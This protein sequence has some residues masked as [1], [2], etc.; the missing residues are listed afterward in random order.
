MMG[1]GGGGVEI[2][3]GGGGVL[4]GCQ[5]GEGAAGCL[6]DCLEAVGCQGGSR[7]IKR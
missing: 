2:L 5:N 6:L 4:G 7:M 3:E 1:T